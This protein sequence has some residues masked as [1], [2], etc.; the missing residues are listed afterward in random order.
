MR[1]SNLKRTTGIVAF[2][3]QQSTFIMQQGYEENHVQS[4]SKNS[5][6]PEEIQTSVRERAPPGGEPQGE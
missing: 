3:V 5:F 1:D 6:I 2:W 4:Y